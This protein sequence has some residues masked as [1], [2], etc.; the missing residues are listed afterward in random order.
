M[1]DKDSKYTSRSPFNVLID[2]VQFINDDIK[3]LSCIL[4]LHNSSIYF[5]FRTFEF[6]VQCIYW[7]L[8]FCDIDLDFLFDKVSYITK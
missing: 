3:L 1:S 7:S 8:S 2:L 6:L 5:S 4:C